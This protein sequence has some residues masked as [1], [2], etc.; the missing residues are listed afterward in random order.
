MKWE[1]ASNR[2]E[3]TDLGK[4]NVNRLSFSELMDFRD[5]CKL[6]VHEAQESNRRYIR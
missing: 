3:M 1:F 2:L 4:Y 5:C 6:S